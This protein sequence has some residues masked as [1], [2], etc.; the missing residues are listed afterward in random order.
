MK[1]IDVFNKIFSAIFF[2]WVGGML[3][4][5]A[6]ILLD[7]FFDLQFM[8]YVLIPVSIVDAIILFMS[9]RGEWKIPTFCS[10]VGENGIARYAFEKEPSVKYGTGL[11]LFHQ[12]EELRVDKI[13]QFVNGIYQNTIYNF[14][15]RNADNKVVFF[16]GG[17]YHS[18][19]D[20]PPPLDRYYF[21]LAAEKA[22]SLF[23]FELIQ[24]ELKQNG[25]V[26]FRLHKNDAIIISK[27]YIE[28][29]QKGDS[30]RFNSEEINQI[31]ISKGIIQ[32]IPKEVRPSFLGFNHDC[33]LR[34]P[35]K[36]IANARIF[37][38]VFDMLINQK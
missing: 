16:I 28:L 4:F 11:F 12:A 20:N 8:N 27:D 38:L 35:Y 10:Y 3:V 23:K 30:I 32:I 1:R 36:D 34:I 22:W 13:Q 7:G 2:A 19:E 33:I 24:Q 18:R 9:L 21:A 25:T 14:E 26:K 6:V 29:F 37:I 5:V 31:N 17:L 15:W